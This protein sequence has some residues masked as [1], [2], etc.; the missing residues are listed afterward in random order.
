MGA[1]RFDHGADSDRGIAD[2]SWYRHENLDLNPA[3]PC[4]E[5]QRSKIVQ[6]IVHDDD[7]LKF[8]HGCF[9]SDWLDSFFTEESDIGTEDFVG[10][11]VGCNKGTDAVLAARMGMNDRAYD[12]PAWLET[13]GLGHTTVCPNKKQKKIYLPKRN[14]EMHCIEPMPNNFRAVDNA[15]NSLGLM[16]E[17]FVV[18]NA[19]VS[20][21]NGVV[22]FPDGKAGLEAYGIS[23]CDQTT[24]K[25]SFCVN[26]PMYSLDSYVQKF[27]K[28][29]GPITFLSID[30][31]GW[32]F[33]VLFG[34]SSTIDRTFYLEFEYHQ[35]GM[36]CSM[37]AI[38]WFSVIPLWSDCC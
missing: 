6:Q 10:I 11:S 15:S 13:I 20:A 4:T 31:E 5:E 14:G 28:S 12:A 23:N 26:V 17:G 24:D 36:F 18:T 1:T 16:K 21:R 22:K 19:A 3:T 33:D 27:V 7:N 2:L 38:C 8:R 25:N 29:R 30:T 32:D 34:G 37:F 35:A 9:D